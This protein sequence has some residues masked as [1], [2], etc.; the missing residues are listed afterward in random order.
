MSRG[1]YAMKKKKDRAN[2]L[3]YLPKVEKNGTSLLTN[4]LTYRLKTK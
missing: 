2:L 1:F 3:I 4:S